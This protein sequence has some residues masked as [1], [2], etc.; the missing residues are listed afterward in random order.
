MLALITNSCINKKHLKIVN[1]KCVILLLVWQ[2]LSGC[3]KKPYLLETMETYA[4]RLSNVLD[5][6]HPVSFELKDALMSDIAYKQKTVE[7]EKMPALISETIQLREFYDLP[8][9]GLKPLIAQRNTTLGK[10]QSPSQRYLYEVLLVKTLR[11]CLVKNEKHSEALQ[12]ILK[13]KKQVMFHSWQLFLH[14]S[15]EIASAINSPHSHFRDSENHDYALQSWLQLK[16]FSPALLSSSN[17]VESQG[18]ALEQHLKTINDYKTPAKLLNDY[19][20]V[21]YWLPEITQFLEAETADFTCV[22]KREKQKVQYLRNVFHL[23]FIEKIQ[24]LT[25]KMNKWYYKQV[26]ILED[27]EVVSNDRP[28]AASLPQIKVNYDKA[29]LDH[30]QFW[31]Q[32][33]KRCDVSPMK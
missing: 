9:C 11:Q 7:T 5:T 25:S 22:P 15:K 23:F 26:P 4:Q 32:L 6:E 18:A 29:L 13:I 19:T 28:L 1:I 30:V 27:L 14:N 12:Q 8:D 24:P 16:N 3:G 2:V 20:L 33:F 17:D 10:I 21:Q 31:Q